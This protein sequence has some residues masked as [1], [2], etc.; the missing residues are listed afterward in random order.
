MALFALKQN[1]AAVRELRALITRFP[2]SAEA[3]QARSKL[4]GMGVPIVPRHAQ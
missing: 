4:N 3:T 1:D 2:T